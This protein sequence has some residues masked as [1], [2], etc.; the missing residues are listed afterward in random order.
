MVPKGGSRPFASSTH[1]VKA[2]Q[3]ARAQLLRKGNEGGLHEDAIMY[4]VR[5]MVYLAA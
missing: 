5:M 3:E 4:S 2:V 1:D